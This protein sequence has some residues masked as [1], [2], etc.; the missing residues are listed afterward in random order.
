M[1]GR[2]EKVAMQNA[3]EVAVAVDGPRLCYEDHETNYSKDDYE[4]QRTAA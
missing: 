1:V 2:Y 3:G 4:P